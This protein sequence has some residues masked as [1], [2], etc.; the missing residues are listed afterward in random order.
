MAELKRR[1]KMNPEKNFISFLMNLNHRGRHLRRVGIFVLLGAPA[2]ALQ[3]G[4]EPDLKTILQKSAEASEI[5]FKAAPQYNYKEHDR[6]SSGTKTYA[7]TMLDGSPYQ[8]LIAVDDKALP[9]AQATEELKKQHQA[10][11]RRR[12]QSS[13]QRKR[14]IAKYEHERA[15]EHEMMG[16]LSVAFEFKLNGKTKLRGFNV[17]V[18]EATPRAEY[19]PPN[20]ESQALKGMEGELW[21]DQASYRW[22]KVTAKVIRPVTIGGFLARVQPGTQ[23]EVEKSPVGNGIW[24]VTHFAM[25]SRAKVLMLVSRHEAEEDT[26]SDFERVNHD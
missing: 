15:G 1:A 18:L 8:R 16:Q 26:F 24:Q 2:W 6:T 13:W 5:D 19:R 25:Q 11:A 20:M 7:V 12:A 23:F 9:A 17:W 21:I 4:S 22:V 10:E 3:S 14:R